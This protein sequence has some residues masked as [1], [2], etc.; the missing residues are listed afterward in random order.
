MKNSPHNNWSLHNNLPGKFR[1]V[2]P[3]MP[4]QNMTT[5]PQS[6]ETVHIGATAVTLK[7]SLEQNR[8]RK[9]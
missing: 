1:N 7:H 5:Q 6:I 9:N 3:E 8:K 2:V 4:T